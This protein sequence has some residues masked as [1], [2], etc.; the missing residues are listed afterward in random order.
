MGIRLCLCTERERQHG[1]SLDSSKLQEA[2]DSRFFDDCSQGGRRD[3][4]ALQQKYSQD[5]KSIEKEIPLNS[6]HEVSTAAIKEDS[7]KDTQEQ[8]L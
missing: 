8:E 2:F 1:M 6:S 7:V 4:N 3:S 5:D